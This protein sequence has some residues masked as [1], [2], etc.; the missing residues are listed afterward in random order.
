MPILLR[1]CQLSVD[2]LSILGSPAFTIKKL[3]FFP[4]RAEETCPDF[5]L[6][7]FCLSQCRLSYIDCTEECE[8]SSCQNLCLL[9]FQDCN[10]FCPCEVGCPEGCKN[11]DNPLCTE[12]SPADH[13]IMV[14][15][16]YLSKAYSI[17]GDGK[18]INPGYSL[19]APSDDYAKWSANA[20]FSDQLFIFGG[21]S[22]RK[23]VAQLD[24]CEFKELHMRLSIE[25]YV[26]TAALTA[27]NDD[28]V[29]ICFGTNSENKCNLFTGS[30]VNS[31]S[32]T[33][34]GHR[35]G[36]LGYYHG[37]PTTVSSSSTDGYSKVE[38]L[39]EDGSWI[40][41]SDHPRHQ[42]FSKYYLV[43]NLSN[44][45]AHNLIGL[46]SGALMMVGGYKRQTDDYVT[47]IWLLNSE[48]WSLVG[49]LQKSVAYGSVLSIDS[50]VYIFGGRG[51]TEIAWEYQYP[52]QRIDLDKEEEIENVTEIG[53]HGEHFY[54]PV[55]FEVT[56][57]FC[58]MI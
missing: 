43:F 33:T 27:I 21:D 9:N 12:K 52:I 58:R 39:A 40:R 6:N 35:H 44:I 15:P 19:S 10:D 45:H 3:S 24:G 14:I 51:D 31:V 2:F 46:P 49:D 34:F 37:R 53:S 8:S 23:K 11:C 54:N 28:H 20:I 55:I 36:S 16:E 32:S 30:A 26:G 47:D 7:D 18:L 50:S 38:S 42:K 29:L 48:E 22:D 1:K 25:A 57:E 5:E 41:Q 56:D 4:D 17:S 13:Q